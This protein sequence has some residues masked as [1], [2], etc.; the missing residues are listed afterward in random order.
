MIQSVR[1]FTLHAEVWVLESL[2][3]QTLVIKTWENNVFK[4]VKPCGKIIGIFL[5][6][7]ITK[8]LTNVQNL[9]LSSCRLQSLQSLGLGSAL[10]L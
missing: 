3:R 1:A 8:F 7:F 9:S 2:P 6:L 5:N 4:F 10:I